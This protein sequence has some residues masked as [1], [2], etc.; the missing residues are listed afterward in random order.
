VVETPIPK[1]KFK[2]GTVVRYAA[3]YISI[4]VVVGTVGLQLAAYFL[5]A[6]WWFM[7]PLIILGVRSLHLIEHNHVHLSIFRQKY[8]NEAIGYLFY[9][10]NGV[11]VEVY[12]LHH[13]RNHH[14]FS[15]QWGGKDN[16]WSST[17]GFGG[18][19]YPAKPVS[20]IYYCL[21][22]APLALMHTLIEFI[23]NPGTSIFW[24]YMRSNA[25]FLVANGLMIYFNP[26]AWV[27]F[28]GLPIAIVWIGLGVSNYSHHA[29]C[30][31]EG[32][33][34]SAIENLRLPYRALGFNIGYHVEHHLKPTLHWSQLPKYHETQ[35]DKIPAE[36][37]HLPR[38]GKKK[39]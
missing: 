2:Q 1:V 5:G 39:D 35:K 14:R 8:L 10:S 29:G 20:R 12:D 31:R 6:G 15:Q 16:D 27:L 18:C 3:D 34:S 36:N 7:L 9:L 30:D 33:H 24:S 22:F 28:F 4:G 25:V 21:S 19:E 11:A 37:F 23:R 32:T 13:V 17:F 38:T 26:L